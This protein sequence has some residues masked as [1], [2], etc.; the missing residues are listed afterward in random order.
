MT[1]DE[2]IL[3]KLESIESR[4]SKLETGTSDKK[5]ISEER[6]EIA[7]EGR[8]ESKE[9]S[10]ENSGV[11]KTTRI[12]VCDSCGHNLQRDDDFF[13]CKTCG[14]KLDE[15]CAIDFRNQT[16]CP[17][18]LRGVYPLSRPGFK[19]LLIVA[20]NISDEGN[21]HRISGI[22]KKD[23][24]EIIQFLLGS[25]YVESSLIY[26]RKTSERGR[27]ALS[28]YAQLWGGRGDMQQLDEEIKRF[29]SEQ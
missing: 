10:K 12:S 28:A 9:L 16:I 26:G 17:D 21:V 2:E 22:P 20:N 24:K 23:V 3:R 13:I 7:E 4:L 18:D 29:V 1:A 11:V 8:L 6:T 15:D 14:K 19:V 5:I 27:E 25:G